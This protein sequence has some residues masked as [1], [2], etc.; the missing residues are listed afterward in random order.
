MDEET[1][2]DDT[3]KLSD[4]ALDTL[5]RKARSHD[6]FAPAAVTNE[7][8]HAI[9]EIMKHGPTTSRKER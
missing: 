6:A 4:T 2:S 7:Q 5:F 9:H 1:M 3:Q 8:L